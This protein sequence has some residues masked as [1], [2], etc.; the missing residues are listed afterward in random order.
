M[1]IKEDI[2]VIVVGVEKLC[3]EI[4]DLYFFLYCLKGKLNF[5]VNIY[6]DFVNIYKIVFDVLLIQLL[7]YS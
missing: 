6:K 4:L 1:C 3:I 7:V 5:F 2:N